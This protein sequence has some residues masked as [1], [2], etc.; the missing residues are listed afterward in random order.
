M[1]TPLFLIV[2]LVLGAASDG[3]SDGSAVER[4]LASANAALETG[5]LERARSEIERALERDPNSVPAWEVLARWAEKQEDQDGLVHAL[6]RQLA[7]ARAQK[8]DKKA[9]VPLRARLAALDPVAAELTAL[10]TTFVDKYVKL[11]DA[12][13]KAKRPHSAIA[14]YRS[15]LALDPERAELRS[16]IERLA[17][18]PDPSL[19][20]NA[21]PRDLLEGISAEWI[22]EHDQEHGTW[23][24]RARLERENYVT[25]TDAGYE[26]LVLAAEAMEQ[27]N[28]FYRRFFRYGYGEDK[29]SPSRI[30]LRIFR[31]RDEYLELGEGPPVEWSGGH[32]TGGAVETYVEGGFENMTGTLFHEAAH[33]FVSLA[34]NAAGWMNEGLASFFEGSRI[35]ANGTVIT[36]LPANH[37][38]FSLVERMEKGWM[39]SAQ[40]GIDP[41]DPD[42]EPRTAPTFRIVLEDQYEWG[43]PWYAPTW[44]VVYFLYNYQDPS[45]GR[46][47]FRKSF[48]EYVDKSGG[49]MGEGAI[50]TFEELV[51]GNPAPVTPGEFT[52]SASPRTVDELNGVWK[53]WLVELA[54]MQS[55][56]SKTVPPYGQWAEN[57]RKRG[58]VEDA[59]EFYERALA[60]A[61]ADAPLLVDFAECL[62]ETQQNDRAAKLLQQAAAVIESV[63]KPDAELLKHVES[64]LRKL[65]P[66]YQR[67]E[68][69]RSSLVADASRL[70]R[71]YLEQGLNLMAMEVSHELGNE[72]SE[73]ALFTLFEEAVTKEGHSLARWRLAYNEQDLRGWNAAG[74]EDTFRPEGEILEGR[75]GTYEGGANDYAFLTL[76]EVTSGD[77]SLEAEV[78]A[79]YG[80]VKFAGL[81]FGRKSQSDFHGLVLYPPAPGR[82]GFVNLASFYGGSSSETWRRNPIREKESAPADPALTKSEGGGSFFKLRID[83]TGKLV[84]VWVDDEFVVSQEFPQVDVLRGSFGLFLGRG[85]ARFRNIRYLARNARDVAAPIERKLRLQRPEG[86]SASVN[87]SWVGLV[88]PFPE[89]QEWLQEPRSSWDEAHGW[90][91]LLV[92]WSVQQNDLV[93]IDEWLRALAEQNAGLGLRL[94][95]VVQGWDHALLPEYLVQHPFPGSLAVDETEGRQGLG[96]TFARYEIDRFHLPRVLLL[97]ID[98]KVVWEGDPG[99]TRDQP[100]KGEESL[101]DA[102]LRELAAKRRLTEFAAWRARWPDARSAL[103]AGDVPGAIPVLREA[104]TFD[105]AVSAEVAEALARLAALEEALATAE[106]AAATL[107]GQGREPALEVLLRWGEALGTRVQSTKPIKAALKSDSLSAWKRSQA[108]LKPMLARLTAGKLPPDLPEVLGRIE[109]LPGAFP[110]E[111][112]E[113]LRAAGDDP[114]ALA[115]AIES[116]SEMP[117]LWLVTEYFRW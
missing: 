38:L 94:V 72:L 50:E 48:A 22:A 109:P 30:A 90:P 11:A 19:A 20:E 64:R 98:G 14:A 68:D 73:P 66:H 105:P 56:S 5:D 96:A 43:P 112:L 53:D 87:G 62:A 9:L 101:L 46:F 28:A 13:E 17:A 103:A 107:A 115:R 76:D 24:E 33:Q 29:R 8:L 104:S 75:F 42:T 59:L 99:F 6:H 23:E 52:S 61:P 49:K 100:W 88:P 89:V 117:A 15:A 60:S 93:R 57:A 34:T 40:D 1:K 54:A 45:D 27:M 26:V 67:L 65:D 82:N 79:A 106:S 81:V 78:Q 10:Q 91:Q 84:D 25:E 95:S 37:R 35:L 47:L 70:V 18:A 74:F 110:A 51:L 83:V 41:A 85:E 111:L 97:D 63:E 21:R 4:A 3:A 108:M 80:R 16:A 113:R 102:P 36:N 86:A 69:V 114:A 71:R 31:T 44:G 2:S 39:T 116:A 58:D 92:M 12:Y 32:F 55:G 7:L 77:Y